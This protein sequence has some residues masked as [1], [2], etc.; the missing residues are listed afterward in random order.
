MN[1]KNVNLLGKYHRG[2][3]Q[4]GTHENDEVQV[5]CV[6]SGLFLVMAESSREHCSE[7]VLRTALYGHYQVC[8]TKQLRVH[9]KTPRQSFLGYLYVPGYSVYP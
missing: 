9:K 5:K 8:D 3:V 1:T 7:Q 6:K 4:H 2:D